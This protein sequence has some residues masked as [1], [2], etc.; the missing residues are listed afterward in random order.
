LFWHFCSET[1][2]L[3]YWKTEREHASDIW[4]FSASA[5]KPIL[6]FSVLYH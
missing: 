6:A 3:K 2:K 4:W 1:S 5:R